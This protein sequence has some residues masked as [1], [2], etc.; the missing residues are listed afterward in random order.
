M[1][2]KV[3]FK[4]LPMAALCGLLVLGRA[5]MSKKWDAEGAYIFG[6]L[7]S[8]MACTLASVRVTKELP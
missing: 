6:V 7:W 2:V 1:S 3:E 8:L 4:A 5:I